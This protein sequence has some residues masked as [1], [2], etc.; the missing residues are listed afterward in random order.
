[1][2]AR[3]PNACK[4]GAAHAGC[5]SCGGAPDPTHN[6]LRTHCPAHVASV[7]C[8]HR[9]STVQAP[10]DRTN[11]DVARRNATP[12]DESLNESCTTLETQKKPNRFP[13]RR[14]DHA[15]GTRA[16]RVRPHGTLSERAHA[17]STAASIATS[18]PVLA[19]TQLW[20]GL[21]SPSDHLHLRRH[22]T[23]RDH[24]RQPREE[25]AKHSDHGRRRCTGFLTTRESRP[26]GKRPRFQTVFRAAKASAAHSRELTFLGKPRFQGDGGVANA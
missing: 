16:P 13:T 5:T 20:K 9:T 10:C 8:M 3:L 18:T 14:V 24:S 23:R 12:R 17:A 11:G 22:A 2:H 15:S 1:M 7:K 6:S 21:P 4:R 19:R 25:F 26:R